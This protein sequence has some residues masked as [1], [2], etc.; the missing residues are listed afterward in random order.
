MIDYHNN[1][2]ELK[3]RIELKIE[4]GSYST[5]DE[6]RPETNEDAVLEDR[7]SNI[8]GIFDGV[9]GGPQGAEASLI[10]SGAVQAAL[11]EGKSLQAAFEQA[12]EEIS[13][14][15]IETNGDRMATTATV[16]KI[17]PELSRALIANVGDSRVYLIRD[18]KI[19]KLTLDDTYIDEEAQRKLDEVVSRNDV[20]AGEY[21]L[22]QSR[23]RITDA[24]GGHQMIP[25]LLETELRKGDRLV[26]L[27]DGI[28]DN[29]ISQEILDN[30]SSSSDPNEAARNLITAAQERSRDMKHMRFK[31]DDMSALIINC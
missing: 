13:L 3:E 5:P 14:K 28:S 26:L 7:E 25:K 8:Y 6:R 29:L 20:T 17:L 11:K 15:K 21:M 2:P 22:F 9:G 31:P 4:S 18:G 27:S 30:I 12:H 10:A 1:N 23:H 16:V 19:Q 24:L